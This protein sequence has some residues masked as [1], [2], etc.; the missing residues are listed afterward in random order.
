MRRA[1]ADDFHRAG[2]VEVA[3]TLDARF[4]DEDHPFRV[5]AVATGEE[6]A[7][8]SRLSAGCDF[9][10]VI[11]PE[12]GGLLA[13][14]SA[15]VERAGGRLLGATPSAVALAGEKPRLAAHLARHGVPTIP[16]IVVRTDR[17]LPGGL[18]Y[19]AVLKP[20]DGAG[21]LHTFVLERPDDVRRF[22]GLPVEMALQPF[23][24][25]DPMSAT[26]LVGP[27]GT[28]RLIGVGWQRITLRDG[29]IAYEGGRL[30]APPDFG[31]GA[32]AAAVRC[33]PGLRGVVGV[34]FLRDRESGATTVVEIN[35]RPTTSYAGLTRLLPPGAIARAW[36]DAFRG[37]DDQRAMIP[38]AD[39]E[40]IDF[41]ADGT[42]VEGGEAGHAD[43]G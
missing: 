27:T 6:R 42:L 32:P 19:P 18:S 14:L 26:F 7:T 4:V 35:P 37:G 38:A 40:R 5:E 28:T 3:M 21:S 41:R 9:T 39:G 31:S 17:P 34:D 23:V 15:L 1:V 36:L 30:P 25:G 13:D 16:T 2:G 12:T 33:V 24:P 43:A 20:V 10:V 11:A 22:E 29:V 8:L